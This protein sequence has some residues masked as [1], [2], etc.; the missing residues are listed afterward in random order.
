MVVQALRVEAASNLEPSRLVCAAVQLNAALRRGVLRTLLR[1]RHRA[2]LESPDVDVG[3]VLDVAERA[4]ATDARR[5]GLLAGVVLTAGVIWLG[6]FLLRFDAVPALSGRPNGVLWAAYLVGYVIVL[7]H[8]LARRAQARRAFSR[9]RFAAAA[10]V[11]ADAREAAGRASTNLVVYSGFNPFVGMG[12]P[13]SGWSFAISVDRK[14]E[15]L[16]ARELERFTAEELEEAIADSLRRTSIAGLVLDEQY[17]VQGRD[18]A[19]LDPRLMPDPREGPARSLDPD[20]AGDLTAAH[21][22]RIRRYLRVRLRS[23]DGDAVLS[24]YVRCRLSGNSLFV[25]ASYW[26]LPPVAEGFREVDRL[27]T[28]ETLGSFLRLFGR[29]AIATPRLMIW[30]VPATVACLLG[31]I[32]HGLHRW[33]ENRRMRVDPLFDHGALTSVRM[34]ATTNEYRRYFQKMDGEMNLK[35]LERQVLDAIVSFLD[36]RGVDTSDL[37]E[38]RTTIMNEGLIVTGGTL[39]AGAVSAGRGARSTAEEGHGVLQRA[40]RAARRV[41]GGKP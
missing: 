22:E 5:D 16:D 9:G 26:I 38:R 29:E 11:S 12:Y 20:L 40:A 10:P 13:V 25:E 3:R 15:G 28:Y 34:L 1:D 27:Q 31:P 14:A 6:I 7:A 17:F 8:A 37:R 39:T 2:V 33:I 21:Q 41:A 35:V 30:A 19:G 32:R 23:A 24:L 18:L 36:D 4:H